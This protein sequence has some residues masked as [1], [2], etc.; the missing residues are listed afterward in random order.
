MRAKPFVAA[1]CNVGQDV[2]PAFVTLAERP[3]I[4]GRNAICW[5][6]VRGNEPGVYPP[7]S[8][9]AA[10][11]AAMRATATATAMSRT[12]RSIGSQDSAGFDSVETL[13]SRSLHHWEQQHRRPLTGRK[14]LPRRT[15]DCRSLNNWRWR[16]PPPNESIG[17]GGRDLLRPGHY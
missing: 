9:A 10:S 12:A 3:Q 2:G 13:R 8:Q 11:P 15:S 5:V 1:S 16:V 7:R 17:E 14:A 4:A 6:P